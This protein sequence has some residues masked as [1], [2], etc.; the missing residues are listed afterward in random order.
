MDPGLGF[1]LASGWRRNYPSRKGYKVI[2]EGEHGHLICH[3]TL[4]AAFPAICG[5][6]QPGDNLT[7]PSSSSSVL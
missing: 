3:K 2:K 4:E 1:N 5:L 6:Q 7:Q